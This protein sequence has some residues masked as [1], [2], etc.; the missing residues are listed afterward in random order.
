MLKLSAVL[1]ITLLVTGWTGPSLAETPTVLRDIHLDQFGYRPLDQKVAILADPIYGNNAARSYE[2]HRRIHVRRWSDDVTVLKVAPVLWNGGRVDFLSGDRGSWADFSDLTTPGD[3]YLYDPGQGKRSHRFTI[4]NDVYDDVLVAA[5]R[6]LYFNR[7]NTAHVSPYA[8]QWLDDAAHVGRGQDTEARYIHE[9]NNRRLERDLSGGWYDA[10]DTNKYVTYAADAVHQLLAAFDDYPQVFRDN[11][12]IPESGNGVPD[13]ID[14]V[15]WEISW[16]KKMQDDDGGVFLKMGDSEFYLPKLPSTVTTPRYYEQKCSSSTIAAAAM[17]AHMAVI[18]R[19]HNIRIGDIANLEERAEK[20]WQWFESNPRQ[21]NCDSVD[22]KSSDAD[23]SRPQQRQHR[24]VAAIYLYALTGRSVYQQAIEQGMFETQPWSDDG[25]T[26]YRS[27]QSEAIAYYSTLTNADP[28]TATDITDR[29]E[30]LARYSIHLRFSKNRDLYRAHMPLDQHHWG[31]NK[32]R[33]NVGASNMI[34]VKHGIYALKH[35]RMIL[36]GQAHLQYLHGTNPLGR[37]YL[38]NMERY[39]AE[40]SVRQLYH[41]WF[42]DGTPYD[43]AKKS[44]IGP[45]PGYLTGGPN[46]SYSGTSTPPR[47]EPAQKAYR[48]WNSGYDASWE[49][50]EPA[51]YGQSA[52]IR[53]LSA[54]IGEYRSR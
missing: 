30:E 22:V 40:R 12:N 4:A 23:W 45:A 3:Y 17:F 41:Y 24:V 43:D 16:L 53:L 10:G 1:L 34:M 5:Q 29:M 9:P 27:A 33:A 18:L 44:P 20:A 14:E 8:D 50:S 49:L 13:L 52:Y 7:A 19:D 28:R 31:S 39:G 15:F 47:G 32:L 48:D 35:N 36:R 11:N 25:F 21:T 26:R 42:S 38:S 54:V 51:I 2:P 6:A 46:A 37:V